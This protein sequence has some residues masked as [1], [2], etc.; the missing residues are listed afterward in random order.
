MKVRMTV[1]FNG[2]TWYCLKDV[3][4][5]LKV[6]DFKDYKKRYSSVSKEVQFQNT[7]S[8]DPRKTISMVGVDRETLEHLIELAEKRLSGMD[9]LMVQ[10]FKE[11]N[12]ISKNSK[13]STEM[14]VTMAKVGAPPS[15]E[16]CRSFV[17]NDDIIMR[18]TLIGTEPWVVL[19]DVCNAL[20]IVNHYKVQ[21]RLD[22]RDLKVLPFPHPQNPDKVLELNCISHPGFFKIVMTVNPNKIRGMSEEQVQERIKKIEQFRD[23]MTYEV[24]PSIMKTGSYSVQSPTS[25]IE[26]LK[27]LIAKE[28]ERLLLQQTNEVLVDEIITLKPKANFADAFALS[29]GDMLLETF[30]IVL[31]QA[32]YL[33]GR[34]MIEKQMRDIGYLCKTKLQWNHPK[35]WLIARGLFKLVQEVVNENGDISRTKPKPAVTCLGQVYLFNKLCNAEFDMK[36]YLEHLQ[37]IKPIV[38]KCE[39]LDEKDWEKVMDSSGL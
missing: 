39:L 23:W 31:L 2:K 1:D 33:T 24:F 26:A 10:Q 15:E 36:D 32:G 9:L 8:M 7:S 38:E 18:T 30:A 19:K 17:L 27:A 29:E 5:F 34:R 22:E 12:L 21:E 28:E 14:I 3:C 4:K 11:E 37:N 6:Q 20:G 35:S 25:Y 13:K 16:K